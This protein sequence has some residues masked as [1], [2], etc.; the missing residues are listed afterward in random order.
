MRFNR[1][2]S[3]LS[4][5]VIAVLLSSSGIVVGCDDGGGDI[6][7]NPTRDAGT[8][9]GTG[10]D[11]GTGPTDTGTTP[12]D[13]G[14][15]P[16]DT[17]TTPADT[18][19]TPTDGGTTPTDGGNPTDAGTTPTDAGGVTC[20]AS[21][22]EVRITADTITTSTTW[23]CTRTY[24]LDSATPTFVMAPAVLTIGPGTVIRG[25]NP[26]SALIVTRGARLEAQGTAAQPIVFT[27]NRPVGMRRPGDWG[28]VVL[29]GNARIND[30]ANMTMVT[31]TN[32]LEGLDSTDMRGRYGGGA[33]PDDASS[34]GTLRYARIEFAGYTLSMNNELNSLTLCACGSGTNID[35]VQ[36]H[37]GAD[38]GLEI[39][40]GATNIR[41]IVSTQSDDD[42]LDWDQGWR[43]KGQFIVVQGPAT[44]GE[45]DPTGIEADN[46]RDVPTSMPTSEPTLYNVTVLGPGN[47]VSIANNRAVVLRRGTAGR[48]VNFLIG[49]FP[50][51]GVDVRDMATFTLGMGDPPRL[52]FAN[53][54]IWSNGMDG[55]QHF[56]DNTM[57]AF[58]ESGWF[59]AAARNNRVGA[60]P[61][62]PAPY[63]AT[64]PN[65][66]PPAGSPAATGGATPPT[67]AF[68]DATATYVGA[69]PPGST[70]NWMSG[71][72]SFPAN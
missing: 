60:D 57:D 54:I 41:H 30:S 43:G 15:P 50:I 27:S 13:T 63:N 17:G 23:D 56:V 62:L 72:T 28:G 61:M 18:G 20:P 53:S 8:D 68:F 69:V 32:Q 71:W 2:G 35:F 42:G 11:L 55:M 12:T 5:A 58:D 34:C 36:V 7:N 6:L 64:A 1:H 16:T 65:F 67:D 52:H 51:S 26:S 46:D 49:G 25:A 33:T 31:G 47:T 59:T 66:V 21:P 29:L 48:L 9:A 10:T 14:T 38:D 22:M 37:R 3:F 4:P 70:T 24:I 19:T 39:F 40:G 45:S 44:S